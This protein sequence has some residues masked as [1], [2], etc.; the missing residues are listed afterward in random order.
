[1]KEADVPLVGCFA[2]DTENRF[3][4]GIDKK[5]EEIKK[6][7]KVTI[8]VTA[9]QL[10]GGLGRH[11]RQGWQAEGDDKPL[12]CDLSDVRNKEERVM[13]SHYVR[14]LVT[15]R[16]HSHTNSALLH[17]ME[18]IFLHG[19]IQDSLIDLGTSVHPLR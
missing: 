4:A 5:S 3:T 16:H 17:G 19:D 14:W 6:V 15:G 11:R 7:T 9:N 2:Y 1:M 13:A 18:L 12:I 8:S 10:G